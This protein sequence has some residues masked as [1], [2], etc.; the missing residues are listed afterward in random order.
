MSG[1]SGTASILNTGTIANSGTLASGN[2][3]LPPPRLTGVPQAD[4]VAMQRWLN[5]L[6]DQMIVVTNVLGQVQTDEANITTIQSQVGT[7][8]AQMIVVNHT[9][10][11]A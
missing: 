1:S 11:I 5:L 2:T 9:L 6:Y 3:V 10:G 4:A 7:L 8:Q